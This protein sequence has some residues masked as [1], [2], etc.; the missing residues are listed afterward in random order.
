MLRKNRGWCYLGSIVKDLPSPKGNQSSKLKSL[1]VDSWYDK[2][3]Q[4]L[5]FWFELLME[6]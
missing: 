2:A 6:K 5:L 3:A 4:V 1:L